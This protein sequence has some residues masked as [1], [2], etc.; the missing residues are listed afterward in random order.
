LDDEPGGLA[1]AITFALM[2]STPDLPIGISGDGKFFWD[3]KRWAPIEDRELVP[4]PAGDF[5]PKPAEDEELWR[6]RAIAL[7]NQFNAARVPGWIRWLVPVPILAAV[8]AFAWWRF[9]S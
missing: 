6:H 2:R 8:G 4:K 1:E 5:V 3:G 9:H 7:A